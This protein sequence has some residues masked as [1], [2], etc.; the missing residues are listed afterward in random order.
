[1]LCVNIRIFFL[2]IDKKSPGFLH[3]ELFQQ[4]KKQNRKYLIQ[5][6]SEIPQRVLFPGLIVFKVDPSTSIQVK[7]TTSI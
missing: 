4:L 1:M 3:P 5:K 2:I 6:S 7:Y